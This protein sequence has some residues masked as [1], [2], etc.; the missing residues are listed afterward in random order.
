[1]QSQHSAL[2]FTGAGLPFQ[3]MPIRAVCAAV[4]FSVSRI[5]ALIKLGEFPAGD[6]IGAQSRRWKSTD[7]AAWLI[8]QSEQAAQREAILAAPLRRKTNSAAQVSAS[9]RAARAAA[10]G[11]DHAS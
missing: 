9:N 8:A 5:Y 7:I 3:Y 2:A 1:M 6:L 10:K 11:A 4:G